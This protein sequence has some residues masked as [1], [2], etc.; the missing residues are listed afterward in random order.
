VVT[1][2]PIRPDDGERLQLSYDRLSPESRYRRFL[3]AKPHLSAADAAYLV[4]VDGCDHYA[5]VATVAEHGCRRGPRRWRS[6]RGRGAVR[7]LGRRPARG[8]VRDR[9]LR[10]WQHQGLGAELLGRL[11]DAAVTRGVDRFHAL[12]LAENAPVQ[13]LI[14][15]QAASPVDWRRMGDVAE[16]EF[17]LSSRPTAAP[18]IIAGC[19]GS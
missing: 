2:R 3:A 12:V 5:L 13:R 19:A 18:A 16:A 14:E 8:G 9:G 4:G 11:A 7:A 10:R 15:H 6:D 1:I 17:D